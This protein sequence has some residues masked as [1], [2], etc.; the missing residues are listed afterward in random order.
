M[1]QHVTEF[2]PLMYRSGCFRCAVAA[3]AARK[4]ELFEEVQQSVFILAF[5]RVDFRISA[6][7]VYGA[8]DTRG[9]MSGSRHKNHVKIMFLYD[10]VQ[11][12]IDER[13]GGAR[14]PMAEQ[15][16]LD[17]LRLERFA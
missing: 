12:R 8:D 7:Q 6:F 10:P 17:M 14:S 11:V 16:V 9:A 2:T 13:Q 3:D 4:G 5:I 1:G 15:A